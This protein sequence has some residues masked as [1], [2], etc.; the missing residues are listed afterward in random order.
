MKNISRIVV[1]ETLAYSLSH[2]I[3]IVSYFKVR[4]VTLYFAEQLFGRKT[5]RR[6]VVG[7]L[8]KLRLGKFH[9][10]QHRVQTIVYVHHGQARVRLQVAL[11][12]ARLND[13]MK[14]FHGVV[15]G[16]T[17]WIRCRNDARKS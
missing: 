13:V 6:H 5:H 15:G 3:Y 12:C 2:G 14:Y 8:R 4:H 17:A 10:M 1:V 9:V 7:T 16:A 11:K